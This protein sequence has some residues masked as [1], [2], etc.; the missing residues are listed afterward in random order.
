MGL[1]T[2]RHHELA[3]RPRAM[4]DGIASVHWSRKGWL[5]PPHGYPLFTKAHSGAG[6]PFCETRG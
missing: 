1:W 5:Y 6:R 3:T 4:R 2:G